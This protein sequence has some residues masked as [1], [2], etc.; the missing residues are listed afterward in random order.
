MKSLKTL[1][2]AASV[3]V[4]AQANASYTITYG[5]QAATDGSGVTSSLVAPSN[6]V[7]FGSGYFIETFDAATAMNIPGVG[8]GST[9]YNIS[10]AS[11]GCAVNSLGSGSG[12]GIGTSSG[13]A[14]GVRNNSEA[15]TAAAPAG[16]TGSCFAYTPGPGKVVPAWIEIDYSSLLAA[17]PG[18]PAVNYLG[19]YLGSVDTYNSLQFYRGTETTPF[20]SLSG[21]QILGANGGTTGN[22]IANGSNVYININFVG[23]SFTKFRFTTTAVAAEFDNI[24]GGLTNRPVSAPAT[25]ALLGLGLLGMSLRRRK[26]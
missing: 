3:L 18:N 7:G 5:G 13:S 12:I 17:L 1:V 25:L 4:A 22:Q 21:S 15:G 8:A 19:F 16:N 6:V 10:G 11:T 20:L 23:E 26:A 2:L 14:L 9:A 24:V